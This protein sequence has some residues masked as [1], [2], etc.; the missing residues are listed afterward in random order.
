[1]S[2]INRIKAS[3]YNFTR[4]FVT[5][6]PKLEKLPTVQNINHRIIKTSSGLRINFLY[7]FIYFVLTATLTSSV[8][9]FA[10]VEMAHAKWPIA[11][12]LYRLHSRLYL[13]VIW[14]TQWDSDFSLRHQHATYFLRATLDYFPPLSITSYQWRMAINNNIFLFTDLKSIRFKK[15]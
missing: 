13:R 3:T 7:L 2:N 10:R 14:I 11:V 1:M 6:W 12:P 9:K 4:S 8:A 5:I 15:K